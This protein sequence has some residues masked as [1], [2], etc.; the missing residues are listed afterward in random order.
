MATSFPQAL[1]A[2]MPVAAA[3][4]PDAYQQLMQELQNPVKVN[5]GPMFSPEE[6][7]RRVD[8]N[9]QLI[10][11]GVLGSASGDANINRIGGSIFKQAL[12]DRDERQTDKGIQDPLTGETKINPEYAAGLERARRGQVLQQALLYQQKKQD[13]QDR[14]DKADADRA[15]RSDA[16]REHNE[17][18]A[19][20]AA[21]RQGGMQKAPPG[22][23]YTP[24]GNM[25]PVPGGPAS[26]KL[27]DAEN[28]RIMLEDST[29]QAADR[30][31][32]A[33]ADVKKNIK[34]S[35]A[36]PVGHYAGMVPGSDAYNMRQNVN[37]IKAN[38]GFDQL[39]A[40][41]AAS[42]TGGALGQVSNREIGYLQSTI[43]SL[44]ADQSPQQL[45]ENLDKVVAHYNNWKNIVMAHRAERAGSTGYVPPSQ[46]GVGADGLPSP[47]AVLTPQATP[48]PAPGGTSPTRL[49]PDPSTGKLV[50]F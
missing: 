43:T 26:L 27:Q 22:Y 9:N 1:G 14:S 37:M 17:T 6:V 44:D 30:V 18:L 39:S 35:T 13:A 11:L 3:Q 47:G 16:Q 15:A 10:Q 29:I 5:N 31:A 46:P 23:R 24:D 42:P 33:A 21:G 8:Q 28:K 48:M 36:G 12:A 45:S 2:Q 40:M 41:R 4:P 50:P 38:L 19:A 20:I 25:E 32:A 7:K 34:W 49:R